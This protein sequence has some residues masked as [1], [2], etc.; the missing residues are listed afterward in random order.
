M[1]FPPL[2]M[3]DFS[4]LATRANGERIALILI[5]LWLT[6]FTASY[7]IFW[8]LRRA[9]VPL[10]AL[11]P[12]EAAVGK[13]IGYVE[14]LLAFCFVLD[15]ADNAIAMLIAAKGI[16]RLHELGIGSRV[17]EH[18]ASEAMTKADAKTFYIMIGTFASIAYAIILA[19]ATRFVLQVIR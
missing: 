2:A 13:V 16:Y 10:P 9:Q 8:L 5:G 1:V 6:M 14:R 17:T 4:A 11:S 7:P 12:T 3:I 19:F 15:G 18:G